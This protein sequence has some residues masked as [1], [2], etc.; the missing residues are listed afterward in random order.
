MLSVSVGCYQEI[1]HDNWSTSFGQHLARCGYIAIHCGG[2][3]LY[4]GNFL[5]N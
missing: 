2:N 4:M 3:A 1:S 5:G